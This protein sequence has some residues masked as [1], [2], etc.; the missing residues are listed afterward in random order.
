VVLYCFFLYYLWLFILF[1]PLLA[2]RRLVVNDHAV[3]VEAILADPTA[4][5]WLKNAVQTALSRDPVDAANDAEILMG[6]LE[7][8]AA[9]VLAE[10]GVKHSNDLP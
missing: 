6:V 1:V 2:G 5:T 10:P 4:S 3:S 8:R 7:S 9:R